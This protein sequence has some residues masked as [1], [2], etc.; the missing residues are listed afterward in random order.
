MS[1][2]RLASASSPIDQLALF[3]P[4]PLSIAELPPRRGVTAAFPIERR[5]VAV[6][7]RL[8]GRIRAEFQEMPGVCLTLQQA[9]RLFGLPEDAC[10]RILSGLAREGL[11]RRK[12][13][14]SYGRSDVRP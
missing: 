5:N 13:D 11:L 8:V 6:R 7:E 10:A 14:G 2:P 3:K 4:K 9:R 12:A 1:V